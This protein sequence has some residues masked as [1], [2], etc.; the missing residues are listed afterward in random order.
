MV[1]NYPYTALFM[2]QPRFLSYSG[3]N[4]TFLSQGFNYPC[5]RLTLGGELVWVNMVAQTDPFLKNKENTANVVA[6]DNMSSK[7]TSP[8]KAR[9]FGLMFLY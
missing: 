4:I 1:F 3:F 9:A 6:G 8:C 5:L 2:I 7:C